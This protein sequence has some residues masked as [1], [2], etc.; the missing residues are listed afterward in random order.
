MAWLRSHPATMERRVAALRRIGT[1]VEYHEYQ[2]LGHGFGP[3]TG[4]AAEG[5]IALAVRFW[6]RAIRHGS[7]R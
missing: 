5:W 3:G 2:N 4:T 6:E 1:E 7:A